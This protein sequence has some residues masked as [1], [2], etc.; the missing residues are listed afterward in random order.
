MLSVTGFILVAGR[1]FLAQRLT[2]KCP[3]HQH[4]TG[5]A[6]CQISV[7]VCMQVVGVVT[8]WLVFFWAVFLLVM[9]MTY[10]FFS[11]LGTQV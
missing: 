5:K 7:M 11:I 6:H 4:N 2:S 9:S 3:N 10:I 1:T 8:G